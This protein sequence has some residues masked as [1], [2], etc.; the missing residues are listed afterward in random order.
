[1]V[2]IKSINSDYSTAHRSSIPQLFLRHGVSSILLVEHVKWNDEQISGVGGRELLLPAAFSINVGH[3][4]HPSA[5]AADGID[6]DST[7]FRLP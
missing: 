2:I 3:A 1:M 4:P 5:S 6:P 7:A